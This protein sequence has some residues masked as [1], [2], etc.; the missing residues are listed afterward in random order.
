MRGWAM[1]LRLGMDMYISVYLEAKEGPCRALPRRRALL[2][3]YQHVA[4]VTHFQASSR[5][6][7]PE[8]NNAFGKTR[9][10]Y[11]RDTEN[12]CRIAGRW[13]GTRQPRCFQST[14]M[15]PEVSSATET[16]FST[17]A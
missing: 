15:C 17:T 11:G 13:H 1:R 6:L 2:E 3:G 10:G 8:E 4:F 9:L 12:A 5:A 7:L 14:K 16:T